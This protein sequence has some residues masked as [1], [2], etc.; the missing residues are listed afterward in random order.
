M[1]GGLESALAQC[2]KRSV[3]YSSAALPSLQRSVLRDAAG[4]ALLLELHLRLDNLRAVG[5]P[6][7][8][9]PGLHSNACIMKL[10]NPW[11][12]RGDSSAN[13][14]DAEVDF[15]RSGANEV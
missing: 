4:R 8:A 2:Q 6:L 13:C 15:P 12:Q 5:L 11:Q 7:P 14:C 1:A 3:P 10:H 9:S